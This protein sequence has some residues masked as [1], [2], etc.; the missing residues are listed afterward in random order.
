MFEEQ[1]FLEITFTGGSDSNLKVDRFIGN[2]NALT[3]DPT[4]S[5]DINPIESKL[6]I[7]YI[8]YPN[9]TMEAWAAA[10]QNLQFQYTDW[11]LSKYTLTKAIGESG[12]IR[13][14]GGAGKVVNKMILIASRASGGQGGKADNENMLGAFEAKHPTAINTI[15]GGLVKLNMRY[16]DE[17]LF[18]IDVDNDAYHF[19]NTLMAEG[20]PPMTGRDQFCGVGASLSGRQFCGRNINSPDEGISGSQFSVAQKLNKNPRINQ[21]GVELYATFKNLDADSYVLRCYLEV[22]KMASLVDGKLRSEYL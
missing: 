10:N 15:K 20:Q 9:E 2:G 22:N 6:I 4:R 18:P 19:N 16:N 14:Q 11:E 21:K 17:Y 7:D 3:A 13:N 5:Y 1:L 8:T 12:F